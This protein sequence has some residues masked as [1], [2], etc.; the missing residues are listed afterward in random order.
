MDRE[1]AKVASSGSC[2]ESNE[3]SDMVDL[4]RKEYETGM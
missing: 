4:R 2:S 3:Y 1:T